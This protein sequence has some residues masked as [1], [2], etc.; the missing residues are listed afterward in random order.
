MLLACP[1]ASLYMAGVIWTVQ[2]V[3]Y[4]LFRHVG[5]AGWR[6]YHAAHTRRMT[7]VVLPPMVMELGT[8]GLLAWPRRPASR[9]PA[10]GGLRPGG[11]DVGRH[12][13]R[14]RPPP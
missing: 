5:R 12:L 2:V 13:L 6:L 8:A 10:P 3:H 7:W 11:A 14:L 4:A 9:A 1:A